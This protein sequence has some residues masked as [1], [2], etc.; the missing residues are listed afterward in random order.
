V[1]HVIG[2]LK[3]YKILPDRRQLSDGLHHTVQ[4][5]THL[6]NLALTT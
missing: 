1:E 2:R 4:T 6:H 5:V 3:N